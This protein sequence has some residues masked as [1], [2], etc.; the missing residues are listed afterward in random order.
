MK[1]IIYY[2]YTIHRPLDLYS[3]GGMTE[4]YWRGRGAEVSFLLS[5]MV[6]FE[7]AFLCMDG[8]VN[9]LTISLGWMINS[10]VIYVAVC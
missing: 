1:I 8:C 3:R 6:G 4:P 7:P 2:R 10:D 5:M 9:H